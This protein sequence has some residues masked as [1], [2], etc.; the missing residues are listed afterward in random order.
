MEKITKAAF[1][2]E[3]ITDKT[4]LLKVGISAVS[5]EG[6]EK[7]LKNEIDHWDFDRTQ[8]NVQNAWHKKIEKNSSAI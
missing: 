8:A 7:N 6:A 4:I 5:M 1:Q 3:N 2:F